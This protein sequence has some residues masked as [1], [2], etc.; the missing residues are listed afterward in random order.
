MS[1][2][3]RA[4]ARAGDP[5]TFT[6][7]DLE[8]VTLEEAKPGSCRTMKRT[9]DAWPRVLRA[10]Q[11]DAPQGIEAKGRGTEVQEKKL[12]L[13]PISRHFLSTDG[14]RAAN[15]SARPARHDRFLILQ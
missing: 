6:A 15:R 7:A 9:R 14:F 3:T 10:V 8:V 1:A 5:K 13:S 2:E 12:V 11:P 4:E